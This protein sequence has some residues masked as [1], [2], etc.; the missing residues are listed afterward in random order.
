M[1]SSVVKKEASCKSLAHN[2]GK[3]LM[4][5]SRTVASNATHNIEIGFRSLFYPVLNDICCL[6]FVLTLFI[7]FLWVNMVQ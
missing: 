1:L 5:F 4:T 3:H 2:N 7:C 6:V